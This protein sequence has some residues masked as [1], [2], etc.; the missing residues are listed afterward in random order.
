VAT[1]AV[2]VVA[3]DYAGGEHGGAVSNR[4]HGTGKKGV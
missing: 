4:E 1:L 3:G 2:R